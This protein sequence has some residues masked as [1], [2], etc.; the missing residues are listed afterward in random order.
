MPSVFE[1]GFFLVTCLV[2]LYQI[3]F[4]FR[5]N[6]RQE[7]PD[8]N[9]LLLL[10]GMFGGLVLFLYGPSSS[11]AITLLSLVGVTALFSLSHLKATPTTKIEQ[12]P[13]VMPPEVNLV[14]ALNFINSSSERFQHALRIA[15]RVEEA[16][17]G[18]CEITASGLIEEIDGGA[19]IK[20]KT[21][22][23][24]WRGERIQSP[25]S[26]YAL[27]RALEGK[28]TTWAQ[29]DPITGHYPQLIQYMPRLTI[30]GK[31]DGVIVVWLV[32]EKGQEFEVRDE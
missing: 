3:I 4:L 30:E 14:D 19:L 15:Q 31:P 17:V 7:K 25:Q 11:N 2:G 22:R 32:G 29:I 26:E 8:R 21:N 12:P 28:S 27:A 5:L 16:Q 23:Q 1:Q 9:L 20:I 18:V 13:V 24:A 6:L 10:V